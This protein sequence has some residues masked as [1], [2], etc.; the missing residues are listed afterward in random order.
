MFFSFHFVASRGQSIGLELL[1]VR[2]SG[3]S[4]PTSD[5]SGAIRLALLPDII[6]HIK[7]RPLL[8]SG[9][10]TTIT[11]LDPVT[12]TNQIRTQFDWGYLQMITDLGILGT[13]AY[14]AFLIIIMYQFSRAHHNSPFARGLIAGAI[15]L[16]VINITTPALFQG[17]GV[18]YFAFLIV[19]TKTK[20][21]SE[22]ID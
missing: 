19:A 8:G 18:L 10:G 2:V 22:I 17:F 7:A 5:V 1:G 16:F 15:A 21:N 9:L 6:R 3:I 20:L 4:A 12:Q 14:L 11:Y 13:I